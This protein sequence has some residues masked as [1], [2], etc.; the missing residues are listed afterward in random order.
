MHNRRQFLT[1]SMAA[2]LMEVVRSASNHVALGRDDGSSNAK[3]PGKSLSI[4]MIGGGGFV[5]SHHV[6]AAV[7]RGHRVTVFTRSEKRDVPKDAEMIIGDRYEGLELIRNRRWDAVVDFAAFAPLG[8]RALGQA[9]KDIGHYTLIST[10]GVYKRPPDGATL[11]E[12]SSLIAF[13]GTRDPYSYTGPG[14]GDEWRMLKVLCEQEA[15]LQ[16]PGR[17]LVL[18]PGYIAG[19]GEYQGQFAYWT[20]RMERG[21]QVL[22][23]GDPALPVQYIDVRDMA[24]WCIRLVEKRVAG[25]FNVAGPAASTNLGSF[26][27]AIRQAASTSSSLSWVP[28]SWLAAQADSDLWG[29]LLYWS[30]EADGWGWAMKMSNARALAR[31]LTFRPMSVTRAD[32]V[33]WYRDQPQQ[34]QDKLLSFYKTGS[35]GA[36]EVHTISWPEYLEHERTT[37]KRWSDEELS[38]AEDARS[39]Q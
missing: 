2:L 27:N 14:A 6:R 9:V 5:G 20:L 11:T 28:A 7:D 37:V 23:A 22:V 36:P 18:R 39:Q 16:F 17:A 1:L 24:E 10:V 15:E 25:T 31:G 4:L 34:V 13:E 26:L 30:A 32:A 19:P 33:A 29:K 35:G 21:G 12:D 8:V 3:E 38:R